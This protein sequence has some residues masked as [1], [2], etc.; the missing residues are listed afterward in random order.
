MSESEDIL[1]QPSDSNQLIDDLTC[2]NL[3]VHSAKKSQRSKNFS[4]EDD[5]LL[6]SVWLNTSKD[7]ITGVEQQTKQFWARVQ[8]SISSR[9]QEIN[10]EVGKFVGFVT[11]IENRQQSGMTEESRINNARQMYASCVG[12]R[13]QL[14][15]CWVILRKEPKWQFERASPHQRSN[16]KQKKSCQCKFGFIN[17]I[18]P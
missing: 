2:S 9:W 12:K 7:P 15:H 4:Q 11:Q 16:K 8:I 13:F 1:S 17:S 10:R 5:C 6:V 18:Y 3:N 14:K